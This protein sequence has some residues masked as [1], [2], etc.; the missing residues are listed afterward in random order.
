[1]QGVVDGEANRQ[2]RTDRFDDAEL[3][4]VEVHCPECSADLGWKIRLASDRIIRI[5]PIKTLS[6]VRKIYQNSTEILSF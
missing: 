2:R 5:F 4:A 3:P 1:M 6:E